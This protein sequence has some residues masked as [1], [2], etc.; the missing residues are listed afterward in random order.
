MVVRQAL[1]LANSINLGIYLG[2]HLILLTGI[3]HDHDIIK[4]YFIWGE[5][6]G[7]RLG[8]IVKICKSKAETHMTY[9]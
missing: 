7:F 6:T 1:G 4:I 9:F 3:I 8:K 2:I 5:K